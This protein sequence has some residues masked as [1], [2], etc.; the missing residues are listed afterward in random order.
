MFRAVGSCIDFADLARSLRCSFP[1]FRSH[2]GRSLRRTGQ[3]AEVSGTEVAKRIGSAAEAGPT[4]AGYEPDCATVLRQV[5]RRC[6]RAFPRVK[7][8]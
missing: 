6:D 1:D 4:S 3:L 7:Q 5:N 2:F 8:P